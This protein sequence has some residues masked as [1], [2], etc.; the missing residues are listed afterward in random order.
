M[1]T[2]KKRNHYLPRAYLRGFCDREGLLWTFD[3]RSKEYRRLPPDSAAVEKEFYIVKD[4]AGR[5]SNAI[6]DWLAQSEN[7]AIP[8]IRKIE[9]DC[10]QISEPERHVL[11]R[12]IALLRLRTTVFNAEMEEI[13]DHYARALGDLLFSDETSAREFIAQL[14]GNGADLPSERIESWVSMWKAGQ[15][16]LKIHREYIIHLMLQRADSFAEELFAMNWSIL[17]SHQETA[18]I[19]SDLPWSIL[20]VDPAA[21]TDFGFSDIFLPHVRTIVPLTRKTAVMLEVRSPGVSR[22]RFGRVPRDFNRTVNRTIADNSH[23]FVFS[24]SDTLL[25]R[26]VKATCI[27][28]I[29]RPVRLYGDREGWIKPDASQVVGITVH[30]FNRRP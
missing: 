5:K 16:M 30:G 19:I 4:A 12:F 26:L 3:R 18:F 20:S 9:S 17:R 24:N 7:A 27:D 21:S 22:L 2:T 15:C 14:P 23:R 11:A 29:D 1:G 28:R 6:E 25:R 13:L 10:P 8:V